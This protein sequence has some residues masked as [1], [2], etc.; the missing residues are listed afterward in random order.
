MKKAIKW[1]AIVAGIL[2]V[3][4]IIGV[5]ALPFILP[6][7][8][9][10]DMAT[11]KI[12]ETINREVKVESI[13]FIIFSGIE[14]K[15]LSIS[16]RRGFAKQPFITADAIALRYA[17]WPIFKR[18]VIIKEIRLVKPEILIEKSASGVFNF[19]DMTGGKKQK[20]ESKTQNTG[21]KAGFSM[22]VDTFSIR[23][24]KI[25]YKDYGTKTQMGLKKG[26]LTVSGITLA[27]LKPIGLD[28]SAVADYKGKDVPIS[29]NGSI[30]LD[31]ENNAVKIPNLSLGVAGEKADLAVSVSKLKTGPKIDFSIKSKKFQ[32]DPILA[33]FTAGATEIPKEKKKLAR[34]ELT[35][36]VN[37]I[38]RSIPRKLAVKAKVDVG[39]L[40]VLGFAVDKARLD[41]ALKN[42]IATVDIVEIKVYDGEVVGTTTIN[43][44]APGLSYSGNLVIEGFDAHPFSNAV[45]ETFLT[46]ME[47][48]KDL[49]D[50]VYG[51]LDISLAFHG[52]GVEVPDIMSSAVVSGTLMLTN[53]ELKRLKTLD[54]IAD[55]IKVAGL[56][57]D[58]KISELSAKY[59]MKNQVVNIESLDLKNGDLQIAFKGGLN[60]ARL[61]FVSGNRL[62]LR[63]SPRLTKELSKEYNLFRNDEGWL[64]VTFELKG[65][66]KK[67]IP[68]PILEKP[69]E[70][71]IGKVKLKIDAKKVE[72]QEQTQQKVEEE[73]K[74][75][76]EEAKKQ[77]KN[78]IKF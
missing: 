73:K 76:A 33:V 41:C 16:N 71:A 78:L 8:K 37:K 10:K 54:A 23:D 67:P 5:V 48:F 69:V 6:L 50:K 4:L 2:I 60:L 70:K 42:K 68:M 13:S 74:R 40:S 34:G 24:A 46:K 75:L 36:K 22:I 31:L 1:F 27:L 77:L 28:F 45:V 21:K 25:T 65:A 49:Q 7:D 63:G 57:Q 29:I 11:A 39:Q 44:N 59:S 64:E 12:S 62:T 20:V 15:G 66:L 38:M 14:L 3:L 52:R 56:K 58:L 17:F 32:I 72:T 47:K 35:A 51:K 30:A 18:Q 26:N 19:S 55:K 61:S 43:L 53:G 9:I